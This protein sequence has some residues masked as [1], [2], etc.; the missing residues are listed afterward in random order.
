[1]T[2]K[3]YRNKRRS[4]RKPVRSQPESVL[5]GRTLDEVS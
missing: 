4:G 2:L 1:M 3:E 5:T